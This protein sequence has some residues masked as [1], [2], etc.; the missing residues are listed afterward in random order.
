MIK[1][2]Y[3]LSFL[4]FFCFCLT[5][6]IGA[7]G[8]DRNLLERIRK[9]RAKMEF[10]EERPEEIK[11]RII[12]VPME[13]ESLSTIEKMFKERY[14]ITTDRRKFESI[15]DSLIESVRSESIKIEIR[16][17]YLSS[18]T[19]YFQ[20]RSEL[21]KIEKKLDSISITL[22]QFGYN[23][24]K[25]TLTEM[26]S[27]TPI[28][29]DYLLGPGDEV[30]IEISGQMNEAWDKR[31][32]R[33]GKIVLPKV[34]QITLWG[35][36][37][38]DAKETIEK[39]LKREF[40]NIEVS[41]T[42]GELR[43]VNLFVLGE[44]RNPGLY[45]VIALSNPLSALFTAG[46]PEKTGSL[47]L[48]KYI[49]N[50]GET[51]IFDLY[52]L[53]IEGRK[54]PNI[55]LEAGDIIYVPPIGNIVGVTGAVT[56]PGI[57][58]I[59]GFSD[60]SDM[61]QMSGGILPTGGIFRIQIERVSRGNRKVVEDFR[62]QSDEEFRKKTQDIKIRN[63]DL[64]E[65]FEIPPL[66]H[67]YVTIEGNI[68]RTGT[69]GLEKGMTVLDLIEEV[70]GLKEGTYLDRA[71]IFRFQGVENREIIELDLEK[72]MEKDS[73]ENIKLK[74]WDKLKI[75]SIDEIQERFTVT[76]SGAVKYPGTYPLS[77]DITVNDLLFKGI[78]L[79]G[80]TE[81]AE[82]FSLDPDLGVSIKTISL[83][84][85]IDLKIKLKP[86]DHLLVK[87]KPAYREVGYVSLLG[88]FIYPGTYPIKTGEPMK[89]VI[90]RA[91]GF[92]N[93]AYPDGARF[94]RKSV[95][96]LQNKAVLDLIRETRLR[97]VAEQRRVMEGA[98]TEQERLSTMQYL[99]N[100]QIQIEELSRMPSPGRVVIDLRDPA[101]LNTPLEDGD[102]LFVPKLPKTVQVIGHVYN[103]TGITYEEGLTQNDY[104]NMAGGPKKTADKKAI[105]VRRASGKVVRN[106]REIKPGDTIIVPEKVEIG[107]DFWDIVSTTATILYQ[108]GIA[109]AAFTVFTK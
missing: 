21:S 36:T 2:K 1:R 6:S 14:F 52:D 54:L 85:S 45:N 102:S 62:F 30:T 57:Y 16:G 73:K 88:E 47:R 33:D 103:P 20:L 28:A 58:E 87:R 108:I 39:A 107:R 92:T 66:R 100:Q 41:V 77:P 34:G 101:Q 15:R 5:T 86:M 59:N 23:M 38:K 53:L 93:E 70:G 106:P 51:R 99:Q 44:V 69:Y 35:K 91:G 105:Y 94:K 74:E 43:S 37:Y 60:L 90:E 67:N 49:P 19:L 13:V 61:L 78:P 25:V 109:V 81:R 7:Q 17:R 83:S 84:D 96:E 89:N 71:D 46:G 76:I 79:R 26:P 98:V 27:F 4:I 56:R 82:L 75:Y 32:D 97:L 10:E 29:E 8:I 42:L 68:E 11:E 55:Q 18:D 40:T 65:L 95:A 9:E 63:G 22:R 31:I 12:P 80:V 24:F 104:L 3:I 64:I 48:I 72:I 50:K